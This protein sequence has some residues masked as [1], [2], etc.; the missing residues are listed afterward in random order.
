MKGPDAQQGY[1]EEQRLPRGGSCHLL[2]G[3]PLGLAEVFLP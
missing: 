2:T 3:G 1:T